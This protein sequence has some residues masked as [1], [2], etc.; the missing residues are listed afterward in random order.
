MEGERVSIYNPSVRR[1]RPVGG[2]RLKNTS[3]LTLED[4]PMTVID[5]DSYAGEALL[6]RFKPGERRL[7][8]FSLD[9]GT[10]VT[11]RSN[12]NREPVLLAKA[13]NGV[14]QVSYYQIDKLVYKLVNQTDKPRVVY[15][16]H[17]KRAEWKLVDETQK[18]IDDTQ[19]FYRY[20]VE[21]K[22]RETVELPVNERHQI[23]DNYTISSLS[24]ADV[25]G[26]IARGA[27]D[28]SLRAVL[29]KI[30]GIKNRIGEQEARIA[31]IEAEKTQIGEDQGR[32]RDNINALKN[33]AEARQLIVRYV[34]KANEQETRIEELTKDQKTAE[35][36]KARQQAELVAAFSSIVIERKE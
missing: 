32:L 2:M 13:M 23:T 24:R 15:I 14:L 6:G 30:L 34:S 5:G 18:P 31:A 4:G 26:F 8:S 1:D 21:L 9:L 25:D 12:A 27:I 22:P 17:P 28:D 3:T 10:L 16:E 7:V 19:S 20:R 35:A 11:M 29:E 36:E 33:T